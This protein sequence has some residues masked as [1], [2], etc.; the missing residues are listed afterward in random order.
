MSGHPVK[1]RVGE[2]TGCGGGGGGAAAG[3]SQS[4]ALASAVSLPDESPG[5]ARMRTESW[6]T[7]PSVGAGLSLLSRV[8]VRHTD[9]PVTAS[10]RLKDSADSFVEFSGFSFGAQKSVCGEVVFNTGMVGYPEALTDPSYR[11]QILVLTYPLIGNYGVPDEDLLD[12]LGLPRLF[13]SRDIHIR[14]LIVSDYSLEHSH[15][16]AKQSLGEWLKK[17]GIPGIF[18]VDTRMLTKKLRSAGTMLGAVVF[19]GEEIAFEDPNQQNLVAEVSTKAI[20]V[21]GRGNPRKVIA[22]DC[23]MKFNIIRYLV[24]LGVEVTVVPYDFDLASATL[25][26]DG[27]FISNGPGDPTMADATIQSVRWA[28]TQEKPIFGICLGNQI[29]ALAAG[30]RTFKLK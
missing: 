27:V 15:W 21:Y 18:G 4:M 13:E 5:R 17:N 23:G 30:A 1:R 10:L 2:T 22:F 24:G 3:G 20:T 11:G 25:P 29:L 28:L 26:Y 19:D 12:E 6:E 14:A 9:T 7:G 16:A 8:L